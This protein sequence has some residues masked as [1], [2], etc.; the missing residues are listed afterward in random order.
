MNEEEMKKEDQD[1]REECC[2]LCHFWETLV[3]DELEVIEGKIKNGEEFFGSC[4]RFPP[5]VIYDS[6]KDSYVTMFPEPNA[7]WWC[8]EFK[9]EES[10]FNMEGEG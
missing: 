3:E 7:T 9:E 6:E 4:N 10:E 1:E 2:L 8:G 5:V